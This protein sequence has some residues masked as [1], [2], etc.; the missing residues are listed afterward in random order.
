MTLSKRI[1]ESRINNGLTQLDLSEKT[2][3][4][5]RTIQRIEN[6]EVTPSI[7]SLNKISEVLNEDFGSS[8]N[9]NILKKTYI[10]ILLGI[11]SLTLG[12]YYISFKELPPPPFDYWKQVYQELK[13]SD[14]GYI[15]YYDTNCYGSDGTDCDIIVLKYLNDNI[16][17][18]T[19]IGGNSWDYVEDILEVEDGYLVL[20]QTGSYGVGNND[21]YLTKLDLLG[22]ELWFKTY[23]DSLNDYGRVINPSNEN[24]NEYIIKGEKQNCPKPNDWENCYMEELVIKIN[25]KGDKL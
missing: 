4:S 15:K 21:V 25:G 19:T 1:K 10:F 3:V 2:G 12:F 7:Y 17:W 5:L 13:T 20:G 22:N 8:E 23:G 9:K 24:N 11:I 18:K 14:G 6:E 16:Q